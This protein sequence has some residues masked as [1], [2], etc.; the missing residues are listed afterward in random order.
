MTNLEM[1][2][3]FKKKYV[4]FN[5][6]KY[7]VFEFIDYVVGIV[8]NNTS[9]N[10]LCNIISGD[11]IGTYASI[12]N[13]NKNEDEY[14]FLID[15]LNQAIEANNNRVHFENIKKNRIEKSSK[16][17]LRNNTGTGLSVIVNKDLI[18]FLEKNSEKNKSDFDEE[19][20]NKETDIATMYS[21]IKETIISQ[22]EQIMQ[23]LTA[24][25]KNQKV[26]E[27]NLDMDLIAKLK[28]NILICGS[29]GTGKTEILKRIAKLY[30]IPIVIEDAT[31]LSETGYQG[32]KIT[33]LL[34]DLCMEANG[35]IELAQKGILI[36]DEFDKLA[37][38]EKD[39][40]THV[41]RSGVQR[42]LL[43]LLDG[44]LFYFDNKKFDTS[45][46][47]IVGAG[48]FTGIVNSDDYKNLTT[49]DFMKYG[50]MRELI[51]RFSK[52]ITMN[53]LKKDDIIKILK[54]SNYSPIN[55]YKKLFE[56]LNVK[57]EFNDEFIEYIA[58]LAVKKQSGAR[59]LKTVFDECISSALFRIF[60]GE[61]TGISLV[62]P[63]NENEKPYVLTKTKEKKGF[64]RR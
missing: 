38:N 57:F 15:N 20:L 24:L 61:Y 29:T 54:N 62:K 5:K 18:K 8:F 12:I 55:T 41:S 25:F 45:K 6:E 32:R 63:S 10:E 33:D 60:A 42:S 37:E 39:N 53:P 46:L 27:S 36:I 31:S 1:G 44:H 26:V 4:D 30:N 11:Y 21:S 9:N 40:Q 14:V 17:Y 43:K 19:E 58:E 56:L 49:D 34:E 48:A 35:D 22:D 3:L 7:E 47:T 51:G 50:I 16:Y 13:E 28:E 2:Y 59:S 64:F 52:V 23:I